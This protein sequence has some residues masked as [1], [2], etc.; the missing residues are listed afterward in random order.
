MSRN[1]IVYGGTFNPLTNAHVTLIQTALR[2]MDQC[3]VIVVPSASSFMKRWKKMDGKAIYDD[4]FRVELLKQVVEPM[5][6]VRLSLMEIEGITYR[7]FDTLNQLQSQYPYATL[8][9]MCGDEKCDELLTWYKGDELVKTYHFLMFTRL[10]NDA[11]QWFDHHDAL[12]PY[13]DHFR[14]IPKIDRISDI[15]ATK[16]R[17]AIHDQNWEVVKT[18]CPQVVVDALMQKGVKS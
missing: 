5:D 12:L 4:A 16:V 13:K 7:T 10:S 8:W 1:I 18:M 11:E 3:E 14:F 9:W 2:S 15:S 17:Q 6:H